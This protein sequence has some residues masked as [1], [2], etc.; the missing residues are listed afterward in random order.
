MNRIGLDQIA[1]AVGGRLIGPPAAAQQ[2]V[3]R[4]CI[5]SRHVEADDL[6]V[7]IK[8]A[9]FDGHSFLDDV[10]AAGAAA[11]IV[12]QPREPRQTPGGRP[13]GFILVRDTHA[14][15]GRLAAWYRHRLPATI[16]AV[17]GSNG[18]TTTKTMIDHMLSNRLRVVSSP[19]SYN[20]D[21]G[22]PLTLLS[23]D[24]SHD[25]VV[26]EVGSNAPGEI[27]ALGRIIE[28]D[29]AVIVSVSETHLEKLRSLE[30]VAA[31][32]ASLLGSLVTGGVGIINNDREQL[33]AAAKHY[34]KKL[35]TFGTKDADLLLGDLESAADG[36]AFTVNGADRVKLPVLG[37]HNAMNALAAIAV[38]R[39]L[40]LSVAEAAARL[41][42]FASPPMRLERIR[43]GGIWFINDAYN[44]NPTSMAAG[45]GVLSELAHR[46]GRKV[47]ICGD[48]LELGSQSESFHY[49]L[50][51]R[52]AGSGIDRLLAVGR[53]APVVAQGA[54]QGGMDA[55]CVGQFP[56][57]DALLERVNGLL[58][59]GDLV[60]LKGSRGMALE[61]VI[62]AFDK[63]G[64]RKS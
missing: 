29:I 41:A 42:D 47:F 26:C 50:G 22:V 49:Q 48:M 13:V 12:S 19:K 2:T 17:T 20:N 28:P 24:S 10:L 34:K 32:K 52:I 36:L 57:T 1:Q 4:V 61:R 35:I 9:K 45:L 8:G 40:G 63:D 16:V 14:A 31:E 39:R 59:D 46:R 37:M 21:I 62:G 6:F 60:L 25:V 55:A 15:L 3:G 58:A 23:A 30:G 38:G 18:K 27:A 51:Q 7:A 5:N 64:L 44:A 53:F 56:S 11:A 43:V 33:V 54:M